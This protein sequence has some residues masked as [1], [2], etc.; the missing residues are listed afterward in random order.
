M[1]PSAESSREEMVDE[2]QALSRAVFMPA[3]PPPLEALHPDLTMAQLRTLLVLAYDAPLSISALGE[4]LGVGLPAAS[5]IVDRMVGERLVERSGDPSDRRRALVRLG[6]E[7]Q[8]AVDRV[9]EGRESFRDR[10]RR[11]LL[12]LPDQQ[13]EQLRLVC[14]S[15]AELARQDQPTP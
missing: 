2:I 1:T 3:G 14:E 10:A 7:G 11:L 13:L 12:R 9:R 5:R 8:L 15:L 4:R 6:P